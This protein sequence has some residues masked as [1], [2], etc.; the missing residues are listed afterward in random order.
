MVLCEVTLSAD[1]IGIGFATGYRR[2]EAGVRQ[3]AKISACELVEVVRRN[4]TIDW[5]AKESVRANRRRLVR[6]SL[7]KYGYPLDLQE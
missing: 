4:V 5:T 6:R 1:L 2:P 3:Q 7:R